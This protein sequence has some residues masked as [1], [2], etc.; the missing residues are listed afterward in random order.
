V[1]DGVAWDTP[2][3]PPLRDRARAAACLIAER[4]E[5]P[6]VVR[7]SAEAMRHQKRAPVAAGALCP[8][9]LGWIAELFLCLT[10]EADRVFE[11]PAHRYLRLAAQASQEIPMT[12]P[13]LHGGT[14]GLALVL[15]SFFRQQPGY[16]R[17][18]EALQQRLAEQVRARTW[19][20][21][22][23][24]VA[25]EDYDLVSGAA[26]ILG[27]LVSLEE[28]G[29][30]VEQAIGKLLGYLVWL[31]EVDPPRRERWFIAPRH[32]YHQERHR[33]SPE[34]YVDLGLAHGIPGP[35][36]ALTLAWQA[37]YR[38]D[39][40]RAAIERLSGWLLDRRLPDSWGP[41]WP[42]DL[43][44]D[45]VRP[46]AGEEASH[47][48]PAWCYGDPGVAAALWL[49]GSALDDE[50]WR[51]TAVESLEGVFRRPFA[52]DRLVSPTICHG[53]AGLLAISLRL[54]GV[55]ASEPLRR[56]IPALLTKVL[57]ACD[58]DLL[59]GVQ[60]QE[61][62]GNFVDDHSFL[63]GAAGVALVLLAA[64]ASTPPRWD[65][66]LLIA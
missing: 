45:A 44:V 29:A 14:G 36:A 20:R 10:L 60:D 51:R 21:P 64:S 66:A 2:V 54:A 39:G 32:F 58:P 61:V 25:V 19:R 3:P 42:N 22:E 49:A 18:R 31:A 41:H 23:A 53:T 8:W 5:R 46:P 9:D 50:G 40:Q 35:L 47:L 1:D 17:A 48:R 59:L 15:E 52:G 12:R 33:W 43:P 28:P 6:E 30:G 11:E 38:V 57:D 26:G 65:R 55:A 7:V 27:C 13:A 16:R 24:G 63:T 62:A 56:Q 4:L 34:G 37:G